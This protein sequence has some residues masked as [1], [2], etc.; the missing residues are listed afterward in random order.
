MVSIDIYVLSPYKP[1]FEKKDAH[2]E[3]S[4]LIESWILEGLKNVHTVC[5]FPCPEFHVFVEGVEGCT[6]ELHGC[7]GIV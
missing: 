3:V 6:A 7:F 4:I 5:F 2:I 1:N